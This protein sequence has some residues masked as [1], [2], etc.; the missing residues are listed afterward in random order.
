[1]IHRNKGA[2]RHPRRCNGT[3]GKEEEEN[4]KKVKVFPVSSCPVVVIVVRHER[5]VTL[6]CTAAI[7]ITLKH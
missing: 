1:M 2:T 3:N 4:S 6:V 5:N 7:Q